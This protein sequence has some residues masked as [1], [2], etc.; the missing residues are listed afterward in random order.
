MRFMVVVRD[1]GMHRL[2]KKVEVPKSAVKATR[3]D[4]SQFEM[5]LFDPVPADSLNSLEH[6]VASLPGRAEPA[7]F[8]VSEYSAP[9]L[10]RAGLA[11]VADLCR[12]HLHDERA[13]TQGTTG[14]CSCWKRKGC[15]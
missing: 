6:E 8:L 11:E 3:L 7:V 9:R 1:L 5:N 13:A 2:P 12:L 4:G 15:T 10:L 14:R